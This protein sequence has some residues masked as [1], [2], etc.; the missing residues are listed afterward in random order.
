MALVNM[1]LQGK[2]G[3]GKSLVSTLLA[4]HYRARGIEPIC[5][6]TDPV[7]QTFGGFE[8][9]QV[10]RLA[11]GA[12]AGEIDP[13][14]F[15]R[16]VEA[17]LEA[18]AEAVFVIDNGAATFLPLMSYMAENDVVP[19]LKEHGH[20]VRCHSVLTG[21]QALDDT[22][23]GFAAL[24]DAFAD[25]PVVVWLNEHFGKVEKAG[26]AF[27]ETKLFGANKERVHALIRMAA[28]RPQTFG[29]DL[30]AMLKSR[31]VFEQ[32]VS[33]DAFSIMAR[34]RLK[35]MWRAFSAEMDKAQL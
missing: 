10:Q 4:Q 16:L 31:L 12:T 27:E 26:K 13:R 17:I 32:A 8:A 11:L 22:V 33:S 24:L 35:T 30:E 19:F 21:G 15:D 20:E 34:Q 29:A 2:G 28:V 25:V 23:N 7:N 18:P 9:L 1:T 6:D 14:A 3:V 5:F